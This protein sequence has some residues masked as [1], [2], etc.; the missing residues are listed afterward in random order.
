MTRTVLRPNPELTRSGD[1]VGARPC[2]L[3]RE[4]IVGDE[5]EAFF[6][7]ALSTMVAPGAV[8][9][10]SARIM[11]RTRWAGA[12]VAVLRSEAS[13][14]DRH[15]VPVDLDADAMRRSDGTFSV[16][17]GPS[18]LQP[19][20]EYRFCVESRASGA[21]LG[22]GRFRTAP[23]PGSAAAAKVTLGVV[24][25][26]NPF[27]PDGTLHPAAQRALT[28]APAAFRDVGASRILLCGD[29]M[30]GDLPERLSLFDPEHFAKVGPRYRDSIF[31]CTED[32]V[33]ALY[34][35][36]HRIFWKPERLQALLAEFACH[37]ILDDHEIVDNF[38]SKPEHSTPRWQNVRA[39]ALAAFH[40]YQARRVFGDTR[41]AAY[42][43]GF[44]YGDVAVYV[45]DLRSERYSDSDEIVL[46]SPAQFRRLEDFLRAHGD[47][48]A[49]VLTLSVPLLHLPQWLMG[50]A[51]KVTGEGS[52]ADDRWTAPRARPSRDALVDVL[53]RHERSHPHQRL[54]LAGG[55]I[56][57]GAAMEVRFTDRSRT[58]LQLVSSALSNAQ[59]RVA[60]VSG[61]ALA[62]AASTRGRTTEAYAHAAMLEG[63]DGAD[64]NPVA[65]L[66]MGVID[67]DGTS[68]DTAVRVRLLSPDDSV[69]PVPETVFDSG[70]R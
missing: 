30:Y 41:P 52:D 40:D 36:R 3:D 23:V 12:H 20:T 64:Q 53:T 49:V 14:R 5:L 22:D 44:R 18:S 24:S 43:H 13:D 57:V 4:A 62:R 45:M 16:R 19:D 6:R 70:W 39:G 32:E 27:A 15:E 59:G 26:H 42:D 1:A 29:Q 48:K 21:R 51:V 61:A 55:D 31:D 9:T 7:G 63:V 60:E 58:A 69:V 50:T 68:H 10:D 66:N 17:V 37:P 54:V 28:T 67:V 2:V 46:A 56:H 38:G 25:C 11:G 47:A 65:A 35:E 8:D 33:R 34:Q